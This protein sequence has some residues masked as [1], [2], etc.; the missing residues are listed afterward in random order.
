MGTCAWMD[1][2]NG[3]NVMQRVMVNR[4]NSRLPLSV[5]VAL[6]IFSYVFLVCYFSLIA[7]LRINSDNP[8]V[9]VKNISL[10]EESVCFF[11]FS[12]CCFYSPT[13]G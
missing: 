2:I 4:R 1:V 8:K 5:F 3:M 12:C 11:L 7:N 13:L 6:V 10:S 9:V